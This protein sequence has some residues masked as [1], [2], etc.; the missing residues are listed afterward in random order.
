MNFKQALIA[1]LQGEKVQAK[2]FAEWIPF[3]EWLSE[4]SSISIVSLLSDGFA[5]ACQF[6][7]APRT[8]MIGDVECEPPVT[9]FEESKTG[10]DYWYCEPDGSPRDMAPF[11]KAFAELAIKQ[12]RVFSS[13]EA[14]VAAHNAITKLLSQ[15][16]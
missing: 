11:V 3:E 2:K 4:K 16:Q 1:H 6:R 13:A 9:E 15:Y 14:A 10:E 5:N 7:L 12:R 8:I